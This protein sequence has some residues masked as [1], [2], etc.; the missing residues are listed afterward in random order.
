MKIVTSLKD[1][2]EAEKKQALA[3]LEWDENWDGY[4]AKKID[5]NALLKQF[6]AFDMCL[7]AE[8]P[9]PNIIPNSGGLV[10]LTW[11]NKDKTAYI[12][13]EK[14]DGYLL[15]LL[16][17]DKFYYEKEYKDEKEFHLEDSFIN[18]IKDNFSLSKMYSSLSR[19]EDLKKVENGW[20][21]KNALAMGEKTYQNTIRLIKSKLVEDYGIF[22]NYEGEVIIDFFNE[23]KMKGI[24]FEI[25]ENV[26]RIY[27][28]EKEY[29]F[30]NPLSFLGK[31]KFL[32][33]K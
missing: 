11:N 7:K 16:G 9:M 14:E 26:W 18:L 27:E 8:L 30:N 25:G 17:K 12:I 5:E 13:Y 15:C 6:I 22:L 10:E 2:Y 23:D 21:G 4:S 20:D 31:I 33:H 3:F 19:L 32:I 29:V 24:S 28:N 1:S